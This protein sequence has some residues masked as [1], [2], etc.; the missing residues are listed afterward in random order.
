[1]TRRRAPRPDPM[2][3]DDRAFVEEL[4]TWVADEGAIVLLALLD[5]YCPPHRSAIEAAIGQAAPA[6]VCPR[7][8]AVQ[9]ICP[10]CAGTRGGLRVSDRKR[11]SS[12][13]NGRK[14]GRPRAAPM[15]TEPPKPTE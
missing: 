14:G 2:R 3:P 11:L 15:P 6:P 8:P 10:A 5:R 1:M 4:R 7:H 9:L 12:Q 13:A